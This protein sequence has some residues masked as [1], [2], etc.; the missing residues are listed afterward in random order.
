MR[1]PIPVTSL[2]QDAKTSG[3]IRSE[4]FSL[5]VERLSACQKGPRYI[6]LVMTDDLVVRSRTKKLPVYKLTMSSRVVLCVTGCLNE[7]RLVLRRVLAYYTVNCWPC[8]Y[9]TFI[10]PTITLTFCIHAC[11]NVASELPNEGSCLEIGN[12][13]QLCSRCLP[14]TLLFSHTLG[15]VSWRCLCPKK[16]SQT[17][18][19]YKS[20]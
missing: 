17:L 19:A 5:L 1:L 7:C 4:E 2:E 15:R 13:Y 6:Q 14:Y 11:R 18:F 16:C 3:C 20:P 9:V 8:Y 12:T 10:E